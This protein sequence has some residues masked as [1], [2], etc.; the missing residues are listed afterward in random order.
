MNYSKSRI[1]IGAM[2]AF[3]MVLTLMGTI[4]S[5]ADE[6][7]APEVLIQ[8]GI[9]KKTDPRSI[10]ETHVGIP[11]RADGVLDS[12]GYFTTFN[13]PDKLLN[14]PGLNCSGLVVS[15]SRYLFDRN[16]TLR[17]VSRD[18]Q[19]NSG[20]NS[21]FGQDW[22]F[23]YDLILNLTDNV[24]RR[25][26]MPDGSHVSLEGSDGTT[27]R[28]F[29][30]HDRRAWRQELSQMKPGHV[31]FGSISRDTRHGG[32]LHYHVVIMIPD[33]QGN[34]WLYHSTRRSRVHGM[35]LK[36]TAGLNRL[37][38]QF[39][40]NGSRRGPKRILV[41]EAKL[42]G[43]ENPQP[44]TVDGS[45]TKTGEKT[46]SA[47]AADRKS[48]ETGDVPDLAGPDSR[49]AQSQGETRTDGSPDLE[50]RSTASQQTDASG[51][52]PQA[53]QEGPTQSSAAG[54]ALPAGPNLAINHLSGKV[55]QVIP[56]LVSHIPRFTNDNKTSL[57]FWYRNRGEK[58]KQIRILLRGPE[59]DS[60][61]EHELPA[62]PSELIARYPDD[63]GAS[64]GGKAVAKGQYGIEVS[65][66]GQ[67]WATDIF[68]VVTPRDA[69]PKIVDV[70]VPSS[71]RS[72][73]TFSVKVVARNMGAESDYGGI[74]VSSSDPSGLRIVSAKPGKVYGSGSSVL[75]VTQDKIRTK[76]PMAE[77]WI[78][79]WGADVSYDMTVGIRAGRPG[80]YPLYVRC[81]LRGVEIRSN[82][83]RMDPKTSD[84][85]DQQGFPV[86]VF[87][88][89]VQ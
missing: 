84:T 10:A 40:G 24:P 25:V 2:A 15:V 78:E 79:L 43:A 17:E 22:D 5:S 82:A 3:A 7:Y 18:R 44:Q 27:L 88:I 38:A 13:R 64:S 35:N 77:R 69:E 80:T 34:V 23:G 61:Y 57:Q 12:R 28:G 39:G 52:S 1:T 9:A 32:V 62:G 85:I 46:G 19:G 56:D 26:V 60:V 36:T 54:G 58:P 68:E 41:I 87:M 29:D 63:F 53:Q 49:V 11:Y 16:F 30:L 45:D 71:V 86:K 33:E 31:Y 76:V 4:G 73:Q 75:S 37:M 6:L 70:R 81:A 74:T 47:P 66:D 20:P 51:E 48:S 65:V 21:Q 50:S 42:P 8:R 67:K 14:A 72:G 59:G 83:V 55:F 89:R